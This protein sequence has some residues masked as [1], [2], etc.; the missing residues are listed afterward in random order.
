MPSFWQIFATNIINSS[1][2]GDEN[3]VKMTTFPKF[4]PLKPLKVVIL[5]T[6]N[7]INDAK[8]RQDEDIS[9]ISTIGCAESFQNDNF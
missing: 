9:K 6:F 3:F 5:T 4:L 1:A 8:Y 7:A 2:A